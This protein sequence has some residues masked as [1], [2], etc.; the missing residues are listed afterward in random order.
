MIRE[1]YTQDDEFDWNIKKFEK[2]EE[3]YKKVKLDG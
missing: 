1:N 3:P 2:N